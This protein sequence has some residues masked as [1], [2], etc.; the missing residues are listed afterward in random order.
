M[1]MNDGH[2]ILAAHFG[3][4]VDIHHV[5]IPHDDDFGENSTKYSITD[6]SSPTNHVVD[7][8]NPVHGSC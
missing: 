1:S 7:G 4:I 8:G 2:T 3:D 5:G 6:L